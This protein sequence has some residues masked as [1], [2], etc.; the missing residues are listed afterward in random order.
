M[1][2]LIVGNDFTEYVSSEYAEFIPEYREYFAAAM[3]EEIDKKGGNVDNIMKFP[4]WM[5]ENYPERQVDDSIQYDLDEEYSFDPE[6]E[7]LI[8]TEYEIRFY[9]CRIN[10]LPIKGADKMFMDYY[11]ERKMGQQPPL[12]GEMPAAAQASFNAEAAVNQ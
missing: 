5:A 4:E 11:I 2:N 7:R 9:G 12:S 1:T 10:Q 6:K 8:Y 3:D